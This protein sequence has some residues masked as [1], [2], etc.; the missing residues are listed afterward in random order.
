MADTT[1][2]YM[3]N[4]S[5]VK[6]P[7]AALVGAIAGRDPGSFTYKNLIIRGLDPLV[8]PDGIIDAINGTSE[9][10]ACTVVTKAGDIVTTEGKTGAGEYTDIIDSKDWIIKNMAY[11]AQK[12]LNTQPKVPYTDNG[13]T[14]IANVC[15]SVLKKAFN[16]GIIA[17]V[18]EN[19]PIGDYSITKLRKADVDPTD[20]AN[21]HYP[22]ISFTFM[23]AGAIHTGEISGVLLIA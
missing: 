17:P 12:L 16:I 9:G 19:S 22:G 5:H 10:H 23:L 20:V 2:S 18:E 21:R 4:A 13:I 7:E 6:T 1:L 11:D 15:E 14:Q 3:V 8:M